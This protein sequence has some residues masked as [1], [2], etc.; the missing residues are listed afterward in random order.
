MKIREYTKDD[1][2]QVRKLYLDGRRR[3][4]ATANL[5]GVIDL[6]K[7]KAKLEKFE[8][9]KN[10]VIDL[11]G[12]IC[13]FICLNNPE[14]SLLYV[15]ENHTRKGYGKELLAKGI[16]ELRKN[17]R[18]EKICLDLFK[19][20]EKA[21]TLYESLGF[22]VAYNFKRVVLGEEKDLTHMELKV[23]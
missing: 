22:E 7:D 15:S 21:K 23:G 10:L 17:I 12:E 4:L 16:E 14:V 5:K 6:E 20:N 9:G 13:G 1:Y 18:D 11:D 2:R 19:D 3:E 8:K